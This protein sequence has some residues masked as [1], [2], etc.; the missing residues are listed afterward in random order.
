MWQS[1]QQQALGPDRGLAPQ[2]TE[3]RLVRS[4]L[5]I[6]GLPSLAAGG[7]ATGIDRQAVCRRQDESL[8]AVLNHE[9][10]AVADPQDGLGQNALLLEWLAHSGTPL[11]PEC[12]VFSS[13]GCCLRMRIVMYR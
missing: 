5:S 13:P 12:V 2:R 10:T 6:R 4:I 1:D 7:L 9:T 11:M 8:A 3:Q